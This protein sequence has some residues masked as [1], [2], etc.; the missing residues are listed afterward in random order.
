MVCGG[1]IIGIIG[2]IGYG[3]VN[4][5]G[6]RHT[7]AAKQ[8]L[9]KYQGAPKLCTASQLRGRQLKSITGGGTYFG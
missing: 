8:K 1:W 4:L 2:L 9:R 6:P 3:T 5:A 7:F